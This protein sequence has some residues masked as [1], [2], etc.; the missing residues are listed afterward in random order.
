MAERF[1]MEKYCKKM[2]NIYITENQLNLLKDESNKEVTFYEFVISVKQ[3]LKDLLK[4]PSEA[5]LNDILS[6]SG[7]KKNDLID[8]MKDIGMIKSNERID[9]VPMNE[10][11]VAKRYITYKIPKA[12]FKNKLKKLYDELISSDKE[13][14]VSEDGATSCGSVMQ[15]GGTNPSAGQYDVPFKSG[16]RR[17]FWSPALK[18]NNDSKNKSISIN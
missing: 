14:L 7:I 5:K 11:K 6:N 10:K 2:K 1:I 16:Q 4:K 13:E 3:F 12:N 18:R 8:K 9:E 17:K 15:D